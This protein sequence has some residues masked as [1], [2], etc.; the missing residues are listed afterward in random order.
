M[1]AFDEAQ[2]AALL[3]PGELT[4]AMEHALAELSRGAV[5]QPVRTMMP[6][7]PHHGFLGVMPAYCGA[8]GAKVVTMYPRNQGIPTHHALVLLFRPE[9][10][11]LLATFEGRLITE[12]RTAAVSA[13][14]TRY[15]ARPESTVLAL[16]GAGAQARSHLQVFRALRQ[17]RDVRV[18]SPRRAAAFAAE[19]SVRA[20]PTT[21]EAIRGADIVVV[22][23]G[24]PSPVVSGEWLS[25]GAHVNAVGAVRPEWRELDDEALAKGRMYVDSREAALRES[26]DVAAARHVVAEIGEVISGAHPGRRGP[27]EITLFKSVGLAVEDVVTASLLY[28]KALARG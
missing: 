27:A 28:E 8:L 16:I 23:T 24:S 17:F 15:L 5:I 11:E 7:T 9:S 18:W 2:I 12:M 26:G 4:A 1:I 13:V 25:P 20:V 22:A 3:D 19:F 10:G 6:V 14:A 21:A